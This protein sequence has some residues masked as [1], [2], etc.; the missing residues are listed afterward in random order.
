MSEPT[1]AAKDTEMHP[2]AEDAAALDRIFVR[3]LR[4][5]GIVG[6]NDW[7]RKKR[8]DIVVNLTLYGNFR[9]A[10]ASDQIEDTLNYRSLAKDVIDH[11]EGSSHYL[12]EALATELAR[13]CV[14]DHGAQRARVRVEKPAALRFSDS[15]GVE[16][17]RSLRDFTE[18]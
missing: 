2:A 4:L 3:D 17:E 6:I 12:V 11:V 9:R 8:Q 16:I 5:R 10:G 7:E 13:I 15:V 14:V 1:D 18:Q